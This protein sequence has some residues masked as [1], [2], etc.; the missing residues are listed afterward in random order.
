MYVFVSGRRGWRGGGGGVS[1][2]DQSCSVGRG[3]GEEWVEGLDHGLEGWV[4][5]CLCE[6]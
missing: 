6:M 2:L 1:G 5:L 3:V 4:V